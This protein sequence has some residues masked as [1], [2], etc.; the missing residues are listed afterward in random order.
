MTSYN[1]PHLTYQQQIELLKER[2]LI[3]SDEVYTIQKLQHISYYRLSAYFLPYQSSK[4]TFDTDTTFEQIVELY[5][6]DKDLRILTFNAIEKIEIF[7]RTSIAY[8]F[9]KNYT[10]FGYNNPKNFCCTEDDFEWL[11]HDIAK[12][13]KRSKE[14]FVKHFRDT[15]VEEDLPIWMVVEVISFGTLSKL[16]TMLCSQ[17]ESEILDGIKLPSFV[18]KNWLHVFSYVR[19]ISAHH[20]RLWNRQFVI[21]AKIPKHKTE[22]KGMANDR[23]YT[24]AVMTHYVLKAI[25][26]TFNFKIELKNL[27]EKYPHV[28]KKAMGFV[29]NWEEL[30]MWK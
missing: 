25:N 14:T 23:Y 20:S 1:K 10:V 28:D 6:F 15:Y 19:N 26:D 22:F 18:F 5:H 12:E 11:S 2:K 24:F 4:N 9:S 29:D 8:N 21:K 13:T 17:T 16:Y 30:E 7:L 27:F 3:V